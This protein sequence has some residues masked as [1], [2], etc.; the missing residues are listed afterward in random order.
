M[1]TILEFR[2]QQS[3]FQAAAVP[4]AQSGSA[5]VVIFPGVRYERWSE[6][7]AAKPRARRPRQRD[8]LELDE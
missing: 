8:L 2:A 5:E 6:E 4:K 1:A 7:A 3:R